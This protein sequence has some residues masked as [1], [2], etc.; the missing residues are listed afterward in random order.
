MITVKKIWPL[1]LLF[2]FVTC[3]EK[4]TE[5]EGERKDSPWIMGFSKHE[6]NPIMR[7][8][9]TF[10][11]VCPV[12]GREVQWQK[13]DVFNPGAVVRGDSVYMLFRAEDDPDAYLGGRTSR[14]GLAASADGV[15]FTKRSQP[16]LY[17]DSSRFMQWDYPGGC[18][19]P[20]VVEA[21]D[22]TYV[23]T[24]TS[25]NRDLARLT[26]ATSKDLVHWEKQGPVFEDAYE[27]KF[28]D[29]WSKSGSIV[30]KKDKGRL[31]AAKINGKYWMYW[32]EQFVNVAWS[33]NLTDWTPLLNEKGELLNSMAPRVGAF[34]SFLTEPGPPA[35][36]TD[37]GIILFYN[38]KNDEGDKA[39]DEIARG[40][41]CGGQ[42]LFDKTDPSRFIQR[43]DKPFICPDL[44]HEITGQYKAGT[45][46][47]E[48]LVWFKGRWLLYYG[49]ADSMVG[50]AVVSEEVDSR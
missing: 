28:L 19:D 48:G 29:T 14:I 22:G 23:M 5:S 36:L 1:F 4:R 32:G 18:E 25:W 47:I 35:L 3:S 43:M 11:F 38:G 26:A 21:E 24:Y 20:R 7:A 34:D 31:V 37:Q 44:P 41:Y 39:S 33:E 6:V 30:V 27:G 9:S 16:A 50:L 13:A 42:A 15:H 2:V 12:T 8:D 10:K 17:P 45:T 40:T 46:F 49:T